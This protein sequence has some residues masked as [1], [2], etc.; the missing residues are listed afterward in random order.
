[1]THFSEAVANHILIGDGALGTQLQ[2]RAGAA[3]ALPEALTID[4]SG[5]EL[6]R[7]VHRDYF[8]AGSRLLETNTFAANPWRL[9]RAGLAE[10]CERMN[11]SAVEIARSVGGTQAFVAG[12]VGP[13]DLGLAEGDVAADH[14]REMYRRQIATLV[15]AGVDALFLETFSSLGEASAA[16]A[17]AS[18][19]GVPVVFS[20]GGQTTGRRY[21]R[22]TAIRLVELANAHN[23]LAIG[24]NC[25]PPY[26]LS[27]LLPVVAANTTRP[28][29]AYPNAG[30]PTVV[31]GVVDY[32]LSVETLL[33]EARRWIE[34]GVAIVGG[35]CGTGPDH[36]RGLALQFGGA[37]PAVRSA[38]PTIEVIDASASAASDAALDATNPIR[39]MFREAVR[40]IVTVE[41]RATVAR[42]LAQTV[43]KAK[44]LVDAGADML[45]VPDNPGG[46]PGRDATACASLL[47][48]AYGV[49]TLAHQSATQAN[50]IHL[51]SSLLGMADLGVSGVLA[52]TGDPPHVGPFDRYATRVD[53]IKSSVELLRLVGRLR[54]GT[55]LNGQPLPSPIDLAAGCGLSVTNL[56]SQVNWLR[57]KIDAGA[58]FALTQPVFTVEDMRRLQE[59][60][61]DIEI[62]IVPGLMPL[63]SARQVEYLRSGKIPGIVVPDGIAERI[64]A[65][66][67]ADQSREGLQIVREMIDALADEV[68]GFYI[69]MPFHRDAFAWT[70]ELV[71]QIVGRRRR[72]AGQ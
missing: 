40:P 50:A 56:K 65:R 24:V 12:S 21:F 10:Q 37:K 9:A 44:V 49:P 27:Q 64:A 63:T 36:I 2:R 42:P 1:M 4:Q 60:T 55:M 30:T 22:R 70:A 51:H 19:T 26:D 11:R 53:D 54:Q 5:C 41:V 72:R 71:R 25:L 23:V 31:R 14:Q 28:L 43:E 6:L 13:L 16:L 48:R 15:D 62:P 46:N 57:R 47:H 8:S 39:R 52:V 34:M 32:D 58:E 61:S 68:V 20:I 17:E 45:D 33:A 67:E 3:I 69:I 18:A 29:M 7:S 66:S 38:S 35:C 59:A